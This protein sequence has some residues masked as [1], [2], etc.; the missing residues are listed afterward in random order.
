MVTFG[1]PK[2]N[3]GYGNYNICWL[4]NVLQLVTTFL[5]PIGVVVLCNLLFL[6]ATLGNII[7]T[8]SQNKMVT[9]KDSKKLQLLPFLKL[10]VILG[11]SWLLGFFA[12]V[13]QNK[14]LWIVF[15]LINSS[16]GIMLFLVFISNRRIQSL[17]G[18]TK[19]QQDSKT[20]K[21]MSSGN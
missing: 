6:L 19:S 5:L 10:P 15:D 12:S 9:Q 14:Y 11:L 13:F 7:Y 1:F 17:Y 20:T 3:F 4:T 2:L 8:R 21:S 18:W 16:Q